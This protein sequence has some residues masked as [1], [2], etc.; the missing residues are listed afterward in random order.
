MEVTFFSH[1]SSNVGSPHL[2]EVPLRWKGKLILWMMPQ[3]EEGEQL[4]SQGLNNIWSERMR[5]MMLI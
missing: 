3:E 1:A 4:A 2:L 5:K